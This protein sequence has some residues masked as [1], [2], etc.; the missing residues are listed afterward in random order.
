MLDLA[1]RLL[2]IEAANPP[3]YDSSGG[4]ASRVVEKLR[5]S[6]L[7]FAGPEGFSALI[8]RALALAKEDVPALHDAKL[9]PDG[10]IEGIYDRGVE[11]TTAVTVQL[12]SLLVTFIGEPLTLRLVK[13]AWPEASIEARIETK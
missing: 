1:R 4:E 10:S 2:A 8:R 13:D 12:L 3:E 11:A 7:K 9:G 6:L 5:I